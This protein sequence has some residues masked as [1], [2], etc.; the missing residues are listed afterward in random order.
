MPV[1]YRK[2]QEGSCDSSSTGVAQ[3]PVVL[4]PPQPPPRG[5]S[6]KRSRRSDWE[7][8]EGLKEGQTY[9]RVPKKFEGFILK[10]RKWPL[11]GYHKVRT[12]KS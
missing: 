1:Y 2:F 4:N 9:D 12:E 11:K 8:L 7:I 5:K 10:K 3:T 6:K